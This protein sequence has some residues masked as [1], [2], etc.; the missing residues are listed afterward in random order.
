MRIS[1]AVGK[2]ISPSVVSDKVIVGR[3]GEGSGCIGE[4]QYIYIFKGN[5]HFYFTICSI[6]IKS[7]KG[8]FCPVQGDVVFLSV[9]AG[10]VIH[11]QGFHFY[12]NFH[13]FGIRIGN[14]KRFCSRSAADCCCS[15][16][17]SSTELLSR[18]TGLVYFPV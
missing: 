16:R 14:T 18:S 2:I 3:S 9:V 4:V 10:Q 15:F 8:T 13:C 12:G 11:F 1:R 5:G 7:Q 6:F 17:M